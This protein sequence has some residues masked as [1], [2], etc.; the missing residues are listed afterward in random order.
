[1][2]TKHKVVSPAE[3]D[4]ARKALLVKEK[5]LTRMRDQVAKERMALPWEH[6]EKSYEFN[7]PQGKETLSDLFDGRSQLITVHF[8]LGPGWAEGCPG[9]SF[10]ADSIDGTLPHL[11]NHDVS[12]VVVS[13][14]PLEEIQRFQQRMGW[15]F[16]WVS[17]NGSDFNYDYHVSFTPEELNNGGVYYN[18]AKIPNKSEELPGLS[19]FYKEENGEIYH[20]YSAYSRGMDQMINTYN[21]LDIAPL[22]RN[23]DGP[24]TMDWMKHHDKYAVQPVA[25][26]NGSCCH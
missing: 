23:E 17:S 1:M 9:C 15:K 26:G 21:Y 11:L 19:A 24:H 22:G 5:E 13:R 6:V 20:T 14:A 7:G 25:T 2:Q 18:Y 12:L 16:K 8:M 3:W 10:N 4:L